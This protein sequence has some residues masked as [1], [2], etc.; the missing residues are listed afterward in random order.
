MIEGRTCGAGMDERRGSAQGDLCDR[1]PLPGEALRT[2][3][4][5]TAAG[6]D[7]ELSSGITRENAIRLFELVEGR[8]PRKALEIGVERGVSTV[9]IL[10][11][12][13]P[14]RKSSRG[15]HDVC[16]DFGAAAS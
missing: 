4:A 10:A 9:A 16:V 15:R 5:R 11:A 3:R 8:V 1:A 7:S 14:W 13:S 12:S 2:K 6:K